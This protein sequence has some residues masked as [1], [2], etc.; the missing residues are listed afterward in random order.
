MNTALKAQAKKPIFQAIDR[1]NLLQAI[2]SPI[3][4]TD[5]N[6]P[7]EEEVI[8]DVV[9]PEEALSKGETEDK[10]EGTEGKK[11]LGMKKKVAIPVLIGGVLVL[12][13]GGYLAYRKWA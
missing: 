11:I 13:I 5:V 1:Q 9:V 2:T 8:L 3:P 7:V 4:A 10:A 12:G 6:P